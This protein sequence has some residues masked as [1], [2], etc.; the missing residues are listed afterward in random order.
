MKRRFSELMI[1]AEVP[2]QR[3]ED[4]E[5]AAHL[6]LVRPLGHSAALLTLPWD[7]IEPEAGRFNAVV[8]ERYRSMLESLQAANI[9][10][11]C[12]LWDGTAPQWFDVQ[13][14][15]SHPA[16]A[17]RFSAYASH[18][19]G[20]LASLCR[21]WVPLAEPEY[22]LTRTYHEGARFG[23]R[24]G[25][26]QMIRAHNDSAAVLR[27]T[28]PDIRIGLS[29]RVFSAEPA[30]RDSPWDFG[31][32]RKLASRLNHRV[33][34]RLRLAGGQDAFDF[35][36][37][38][39]GGII[40]AWFSPWQWRREWVLT[41]DEQRIRISLQDADR[42]VARFDEAM[43]ALLGYQTPILVVGEGGAEPLST[44][45]EQLRAVAARCAEEGGDRIMGFMLHA[46]VDRL[47]WERN[48]T[49]LETMRAGA[50]PWLRDMEE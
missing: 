38:S 35:A 29:V 42:N 5:L 33:A 9:E 7:Q 45:G 23:Y 48:T 40:S 31:A 2:A 6:A 24:R 28:R 44:L 30:D 10:P 18:V 39:W 20:A 13:G 15:W 43:S 12:L 41:M 17:E 49:I 22:W 14:G 37:A 11:V 50:E 36:L 4:G 21:W 32:A 47:E 27:A 1:G 34:D 16:A 25:L 8:T 26:S 19:G 46:A 3:M